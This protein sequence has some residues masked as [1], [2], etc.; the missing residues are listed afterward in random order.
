MPPNT[1]FVLEAALG[2]AVVVWIV[3]SVAAALSNRASS[4]TILTLP[5]PI[6]LQSDIRDRFAWFLIGSATIVGMTGGAAFIIYGALVKHG[7]FV[8]I[9]ASGTWSAFWIWFFVIFVR[10]YQRGYRNPE[11][12]TLANNGLSYRLDGAWQSWAWSAIDRAEVHTFSTGDRAWTNAKVFMKPGQDNPYV[13][14]PGEDYLKSDKGVQVKTTDM[15]ELI[16][17]LA[18]Q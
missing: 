13:D 15:V 9:A 12:V 2:I 10:S 8:A 14:L 5:L 17:K 6:E 11:A 16:N 7:S 3:T 1:V 4:A 18:N